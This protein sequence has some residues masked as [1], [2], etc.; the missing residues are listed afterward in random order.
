MAAFFLIAVHGAYVPSATA[1]RHAVALRDQGFTVIDDW[2]AD[3][4]L[5]AEAKAACSS[6]LAHLLELAASLGIDPVEDKFAFS[7][8]SVRHKLRYCFRPSGSSA[9]TRLLKMAAA[10]AAPVIEELH[11]LPPNPDDVPAFLPELTGWTNNLLPAKP[12]LQEVDAIV[13]LPGAAAQRFHIDAGEA[14][15]KYA[16]VCSRHRLFNAVVPLV[17]LV[18]DGDGTMFWPGTHLERRRTAAWA[19]A[20]DRSGSVVGDAAAMSEMRAPGCRAG[21]LVLWDFRVVHR[22]NPSSLGRERAIVRGTLSTGRARDRL[23]LP[24]TSLISAAE[25]LPDD[26]DERARHQAV[27]AAQL[28]KV[29][30]DVRASSAA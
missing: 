7:E 17:D 10:S 8:I 24:P 19:E 25:E 3:P 28:R 29:W 6:E 15:F 22:G 23:V 9:W 16:R 21:G 27:V 13:S 4:S 26:P 5:V 1:R 14:H 11:R 2:G 12:T 20:V 30:A 18:K